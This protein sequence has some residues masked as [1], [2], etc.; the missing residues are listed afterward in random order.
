MPGAPR[1]TLTFDDGPDEHWTLGVLDRLAELDV[2]AT[3]FMVGERVLSQPK[4][5]RAVALAGHDIQLHCHRH[6]RH[7][8]LSDHQLEMDTERALTALAGIGVRPRLWRAPW[9]VCTTSSV[10]V[11]DRFHLSLVGWAIDTHDWRGDPPQAMLER[12]LALL[13][14][15]GMVLMHDALGPGAMREGAQNTIDLLEPLVAASSERG[16]LVD[17]L[18]D[19]RAVA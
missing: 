13:P 17:R 11:A 4:A 3:F 14:G 18:G 8:E 5:A 19:R 7:T 12:A 1:L 9:G 15:G 10:L 2:R 16:V 6:V